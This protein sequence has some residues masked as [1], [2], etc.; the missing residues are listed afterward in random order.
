M[1]KGEIIM[2][3]PLLKNYLR[4]KAVG[5]ILNLFLGKKSAGLKSTTKVTLLTFIL[6]E[7]FNIILNKAGRK[8][9]NKKPPRTDA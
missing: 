6:E 5:L 8:K 7:L 4:I 2:I 1:Y 3:G 9:T